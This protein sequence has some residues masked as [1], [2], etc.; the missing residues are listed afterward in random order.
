MAA[1]SWFVPV[2]YVG[3]KPENNAIGRP[4]WFVNDP[5]EVVLPPTGPVVPVVGQIWPRGQGA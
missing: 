2:E 4:V 5:A 1:T 3:P